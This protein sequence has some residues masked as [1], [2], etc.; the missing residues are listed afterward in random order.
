MNISLCQ[1][2]D[3]VETRLV[4]VMLKTLNESV[5]QA[6]EYRPSGFREIL[7]TNEA[8]KHFGRPSLRQNALLWSAMPSA[9]LI[10][11]LGST[12]NIPPHLFQNMLSNVEHEILNLKYGNSFRRPSY[13]TIMGSDR[14]YPKFEEFQIVVF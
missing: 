6:A 9:K 11:T 10:E 2:P 12:Y 14:E 5:L 8:T 3:G 1:V 13:V 4:N 7:S